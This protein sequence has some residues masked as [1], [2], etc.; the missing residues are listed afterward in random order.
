MRTS[1]SSHRERYADRT[2]GGDVLARLLRD[3][4]GRDDVVV[5][6]LPRGGVPVAAR[7]AAA[8]AAPLD[9]VLVRK[10]GL[11]GQ[12]EFAIGAIAGGA[13]ALEVVGNAIGR[14][15]G[16]PSQAEFDEACRREA[17]ELRR[18]ERAYRGRGRVVA[19]D[20]RTVIVVDDGLATGSTM[21]AA[22]AVLRR[23]H[24]ARV[25]VAVPIG[26]QPTCAGLAAEVDDLVC[27]WMPEPFA[28]VSQGY[29]DFRPTSEAEVVRLLGP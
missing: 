15:R 22:V 1:S 4:A 13:D 20:G 23:R 9:V 19:I 28:A 17:E 5:L 11:P 26:A 12:P 6:G 29:R 8:L 18:R 10:I 27:P 16:R 24:P 25:V 7:V 21:R 14:S 2:D 3:Y